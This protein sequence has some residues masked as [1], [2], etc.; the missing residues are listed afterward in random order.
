MI[1]ISTEAAVAIIA[2]LLGIGTVIYRISKWA[3]SVNTDQVNF[4]EFMQKIEN[5]LD[6]ILL[7]LPPPKTINR[8]SPLR[9]NPLGEQIWTELDASEWIDRF[10]KIVQVS[11]KNKEAYEIQEFSFEYADDNQNYSEEEL[12]LI[13]SLAYQNGISDFDVCRVLGFKLRDKLLEIEG[14]EAP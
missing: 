14:K 11:T 3:G 1:T 13:K 10:V 8:E 12:R 5:K 6:Q 4:K 7:R 2:V 9:L